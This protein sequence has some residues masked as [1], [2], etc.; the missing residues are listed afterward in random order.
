[1][2]LAFSGILGGKGGGGGGTGSV[3][4]GVVAAA[5]VRVC[6]SPPTARRR[7]GSQFIHRASYTPLPA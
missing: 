1:M 3:R 5:A 4:D 6:D 7:L 2:F